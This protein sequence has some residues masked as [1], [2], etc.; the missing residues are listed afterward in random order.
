MI[1]PYRSQN[2]AALA[3]ELNCRFYEEDDYGLFSQLADFRLFGKGSRKRI[4]RILRYQD[5]LMNYELAVFDYR[6]RNTL[7]STGKREPDSSW[8]HQT[9]FFVQ[10]KLLGLPEM[11]LKPEHLGHKAAALLGLFEDINFARFPKFSSQYRLTGPDEE[12]IRHH[13]NDRVLHYFTRHKGWTIESLGYYLI[14]YRPG[15]LVPSAQIK[16]FYHRGKEVHG[17]FESE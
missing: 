4:E 7:A 17:V 8:V 14:M 13:F 6:Y 10:S 12:Y 15:L 2:L 3:E 9:V 1:H 11:Q 5:G 16:D